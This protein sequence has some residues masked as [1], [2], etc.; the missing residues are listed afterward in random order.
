M[1][2][3]WLENNQLSY[4]NN[5]PTPKPLFDEALVRSIW[6]EFVQRIWN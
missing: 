1:Q 6:P 4:K 2:A 3:L 5:I